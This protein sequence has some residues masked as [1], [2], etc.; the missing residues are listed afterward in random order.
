VSDEESRFCHFVL[1]SES[2]PFAFCFSKESRGNV[3]LKLKVIFLLPLFLHIFCL[4]NLLSFNR[5]L[6][7]PR[8]SGGLIMLSL[9]T[10][11]G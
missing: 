8:E 1:V 3:S 6:L 7:S 5:Q 9:R 2:H 11:Y 4:Y 10:D